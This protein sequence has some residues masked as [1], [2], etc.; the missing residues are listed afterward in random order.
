MTA[1]MECS[2]RMNFFHVKEFENPENEQEFLKEMP[3]ELEY[4]EKRNKESNKNKYPIT[5]SPLL[6][7]E[8]EFHL[9]RKMNFLK[10]KLNEIDK[11]RNID[12]IIIQFDNQIKEIRDVLISANIR[13]VISIVKNKNYYRNE[14]FSDKLSDGSFALIK[15][16]DKFDC[17][18]GLKF[19]TY[20][21]AVVLNFLR[22]KISEQYRYNQNFIISDSI[23]FSYTE[24]EKQRLPEDNLS[25]QESPSM[26]EILNLVINERERGILKLRSEGNTLENIGKNYNLTKERVRQI[27]NSSIKSLQNKVCR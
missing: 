27:I 4:R 9:F 25:D 26:N 18:R 7:A 14:N 6:T 20:A 5:A 10:F 16:V 21:S 13:L 12:G 19:S 1:G 8:Q 17:F 11:N 3:D 24:D 22:N 23:N 15:A 2:D